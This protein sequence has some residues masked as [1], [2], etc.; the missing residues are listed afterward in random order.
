MQRGNVAGM[1]DELITTQE[2]LMALLGDESTQLPDVMPTASVPAVIQGFE[3][4]PR[5]RKF[6]EIAAQCE[7]S[8]QG[9]VRDWMIACKNSGEFD[10]PVSM[11]EWRA[12][13]GVPGFAAWFYD[14]FPLPRTMSK[15]DVGGLDVVFWQKLREMMHDGDSKALDLYA[16]VTG[17][18]G[19][20]DEDERGD[21]AVLEWLTVNAGTVAWR[22]GGR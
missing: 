18:V 3:P 6:H 22:N 13:M 9:Y 14:A 15:E 4:S 20:Q 8:G 16:K 2:P 7:E 5:Q 11:K 17:K 19:R 21:S 10:A 1:E 12:W